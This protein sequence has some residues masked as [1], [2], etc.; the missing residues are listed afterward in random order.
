MSPNR[1]P[2]PLLLALLL[3]TA[4]STPARAV[5]PARRAQADTLY[6]A[7]IRDSAG[8]PLKE[9]I[10]RFQQVLK[11]DH[12]HAPARH[13]LARCYISQGT[14]A[15]RMSAEF[16]LQE[17]LRQDPDNIPYNLTCADLL[18]RK[19]FLHDA[20][21]R[22]ERVLRLAPD[23]AEAASGVARYYMFDMFRYRNM[24]AIVRDEQEPDMR[25]LRNLFDD[26]PKV[27]AL[28][29]FGERDR[30]RAYEYLTMA[31][32]ADP[33]H[34][35]SVTRLCLLHFEDGRADSAVAVT[36]DYLR[37]HPDDRD[38]LLY[39]GLA[40]QTLGRFAGAA[41]AY[42]KALGLMPPGDRAVMENVEATTSSSQRITP[43][44]R[45]SA[46]G[47]WTDPPGLSDFWR[48]R[49]PLLLTPFNERRMEHYG[50]VAYANLRFSRPEEGIPGYKTEQGR[51]YIR[52]G[53]Y[54]ARV[55]LRPSE[56]GEI[57]HETWTYE[58]FNVTFQNW[59][60]LD[61]WRFESYR[62]PAYPGAVSDVK[63]LYR[64]Y[65]EHYADPYEGKKY[66]LSHQVA[67]F[68]GEDGKVR[69]EL[70]YALP[71]DELRYRRV[72]DRYA[73]DVD[74]GVFLLD[75]ARA[76]ISRNVFR[77]TAPRRVVYD[78][79]GAVYTED[80]ARWTVA[81]GRYVAAVEV[82][83][84]RSGRIGQFRRNVDA[85][86][87]GAPGLCVSDPLLARDVRRVGGEEASR[88][89]YEITPNP[90]RIY[91]VTEDL[92]VYFEAYGL[93]PAPDGRTAYEVSYTLGQPR[94]SDVDLDLFP[95]LGGPLVEK[96]PPRPPVR[97]VVYRPGLDTWGGSPDL[98]RSPADD[99]RVVEYRVEYQADPREPQR[100]TSDMER[101]LGLSKKLSS[102]TVTLRYEGDRTDEPRTLRIDLRHTPMGLRK[103][104]L[105]VRDLRTN[106]SAT[107][108]AL[109][110]VVE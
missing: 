95:S 26:E 106:A 39:R 58:G 75:S 22:Y 23:N 16:E 79:R 109:V 36:D 99:G 17:A 9:R 85:S 6:A 68:K 59:D 90:L 97:A 18:W 94:P 84:N 27:L 65:P 66:G 71:V 2:S 83:D 5:S 46:A 54:L 14:V 88:S 12:A 49:D 72:G 93:T 81:P 25:R 44:L 86:R 82:R 28:H 100:M 57:Y 47:A 3:C 20:R 48:P 15:S 42:E 77:E 103:L 1:S 34:K 108:T 62:S 78:P 61:H 41:D 38:V 92:A 102:A 35:P 19:G 10:K 43:D 69:L 87:F 52:Y 53:R 104:T 29:L 89:S 105:T 56:V 60:G 55:V 70:S 33:D 63:D 40:L 7:A 67:A 107:T 13:E 80:Q 24:Q 37:R 30:D 91:R 4:I 110:R 50:R 74:R 101:Q 21:T 45:T 76:E 32:A 11:L 96:S 64:R 73:V 51:V 98:F 8:L 31:L